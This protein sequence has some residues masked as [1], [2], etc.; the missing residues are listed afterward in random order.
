MRFFSSLYNRTLNVNFGE[1]WTSVSLSNSGT[2]MTSSY[3]EASFLKFQNVK[4]FRETEETCNLEVIFR[5][6]PL[7]SV[8]GRFCDQFS[9]RESLKCITMIL[10]PGL[11]AFLLQYL[12]MPLMLIFHYIYALNVGL[13][14]GSPLSQS[15]FLFIYNLPSKAF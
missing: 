4:K 15:N 8:A 11:C 7:V 5:R 14:T 12:H 1:Q 9:F 6:L 3:C 2:K 13:L 10:D